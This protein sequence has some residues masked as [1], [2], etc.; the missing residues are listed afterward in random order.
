MSPKMPQLTWLITGC[1]S[2]LG[3]A[4]ARELLSRGEKVIATA[5]SSSRLAEL[6]EAGAAVLDLDVTAPQAD[7]KS[8]IQEAIRIYGGIDVLVNNAGFFEW[9]L[10]EETRFVFRFISSS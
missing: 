4:F 10:V 2:G 6:K 1:S 3:E 5:R 7:I 9:A 8:R